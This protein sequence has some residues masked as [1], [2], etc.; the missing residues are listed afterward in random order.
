MIAE[1]PGCSSIRIDV[2]ALTDVE[3]ATGEV[4]PNLKA[5]SMQ[6]QTRWNSKFG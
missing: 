3:G 6:G 1:A 2:T 4:T 5:V